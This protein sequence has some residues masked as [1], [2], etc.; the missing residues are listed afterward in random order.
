MNHAVELMSK[1]PGIR[2][3]LFEIRPVDEKMGE[4]CKGPAGTS[5][6]RAEGKIFICFAYVNEKT[7]SAMSRSEQE[8]MLGEYAAYGDVLRR[9][10]SRVAGEAL[11][12]ASTAKTLRTRAGKLL[13]TDGPYAETK[14]QLGGFAAYRFTNMEQA[15]EAWSNHPCLRAGDSLEIRPADEEFLARA[16]RVT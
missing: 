6:S 9:Y 11:Q 14:E 1:H 10:G 13:V 5:D 15:T 4:H 7:R 8:R 12:Q 3:G 2:D 16:Q